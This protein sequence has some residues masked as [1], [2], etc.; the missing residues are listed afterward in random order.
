[1]EEVKKT[2]LSSFEERYKEFKD[3]S[4]FYIKE[5]EKVKESILNEELL[6]SLDTPEKIEDFILNNQLLPQ[7]YALDMERLKERLITSYE[8]IGMFIEI[9]QEVKDDMET[10]QKLKTKM[11]FKIVAGNAEIIDPNHLELLKQEIKNSKIIKS[12]I[13]S[14]LK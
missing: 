14:S 8:D 12:T 2:L 6:K 9:P 4:D 7:Y 13:E 10:I 11:I 1:M 3:Y 5:T